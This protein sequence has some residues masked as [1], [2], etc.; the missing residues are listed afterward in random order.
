MTPIQIFLQRV[1]AGIP[2]LVTEWGLHPETAAR[3]S[4][5]REYMLAT[6]RKPPGIV[7]GYRSP[8]KQRCLLKN[9]NAGRAVSNNC[10]MP[11]SK[12]ACASWHMY[13][14]AG[15][16]ASLAIDVYSRA[17]DLQY[18]SQLWKSM[19]WGVSGSDFSDPNHF[20]VELPG[21][22]PPSIC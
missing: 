22:R 21:H 11:A 9:W 16:P 1:I 3:Y 7:S 15:I 8:E 14:Y 19:P 6:G 18:F 4:L 20:Q 12:P 17:P 2:E 5:V 13:S 10:S